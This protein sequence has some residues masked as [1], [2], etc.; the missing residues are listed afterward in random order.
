MST[1][2][3]NFKPLAILAEPEWCFRLL[4][5]KP[6][7]EHFFL[8]WECNVPHGA[9]LKAVWDEY[10]LNSLFNR[11][12]PKS[13][14][15]RHEESGAGRT[16]SAADLDILARYNDARESFPDPTIW[17]WPVGGLQALQKLCFY[18]KR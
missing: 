17:V 15:Y 5:T 16:M 3:H 9:S 12:K 1:N 2:L 10:S 4:E 18:L 11:S 7:G 14:S 13:F 6:S 8:L